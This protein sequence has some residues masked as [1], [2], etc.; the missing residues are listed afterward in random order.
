[1]RIVHKIAIYVAIAF[2]VSSASYATGKDPLNILVGTDDPPLGYLDA[3]N[4]L[5]GL[6]VEY[7]LALSEILGKKANFIKTP[8]VNRYSD[9]LKNKGDILISGLRTYSEFEKKLSTSNTVTFLK[10]FS[11][12]KLSS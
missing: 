11:Q 8:W 1:M 7:A 2:S 4:K 5:M 6:D 10:Y 9:L 3:K 12:R